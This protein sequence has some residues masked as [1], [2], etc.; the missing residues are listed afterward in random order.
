MKSKI[1]SMIG[2]IAVI[3]PA[4]DAA[5]S[6]H[7][8]NPEQQQARVRQWLA[9]NTIAAGR[10]RG[11]EVV[12]R[13]LLVGINTYEPTAAER[14]RLVASAGKPKA[15]KGRGTFR[16]LDGCVNDVEEMRGLLIARFGFKP[17]NILVLTNQQASRAGILA[18]IE[19][20]LT[21]PSQAGDVAFFFYAGHGSQVVN[22]KSDEEDKLDETIVPAD[23]WSGTPDI[24]DKEL[25]RYF[26]AVLDKQALLTVIFDS[27]HSGSSARG[28]PVARK[29]RHAEPILDDVADGTNYGPSPEERGA[30]VL[31]ASQDDQFAEESSSDVPHGAFTAALLQVLRYT[32]LTRPVTDI[33]LAVHTALQAEGRNQI[34]VLSGVDARR[35][36]GLFGDL[37]GLSG[38]VSAGVLQINAAGEV[39]LAG[40]QAAGLA[41]GCQLRQLVPGAVQ[42]PAI[43]EIFQVD[44]LM[45][46]QAK[47]VSG[48]AATIHGGDVFEVSR[49]VVAPEAML[50]VW[51]QPGDFSADQ[52]TAAFHLAEQLSASTSLEWVVDP[53]L[54]SP[55][56]VLNWTGTQWSLRD[57]SGELARFEAGVDAARVLEITA[58]SGGKPRLF[59]SFPIDRAVRQELKL[60]DGTENSALAL[61]ESPERAHYSLT[62]AY[63][64]GRLRYSWVLPNVAWSSASELP[65]PVRTDWFPTNGQVEVS[66]RYLAQQLMGTALQ[67]GRIRSWLTLAAPDDEGQFPYRLALKNLQTG[68][69]I[70]NGQLQS[71]R[72]AVTELLQLH[73]E[74]VTVTN[75]EKFSLGL[76]AD[77]EAL[78]RSVEQ[79]FVYV[80]TLDSSGGSKLL[81]PRGG[82]GNSQ[83]FPPLKASLNPPDEEIPL[84]VRFTVSEPFG[85]DTYILLTTATA[86]PDATVLEFDPVRKRSAAGERGETNPLQRLLG[87]IGSATRGAHMEVPAN[88]SIE[89]LAVRSVTNTVSAKRL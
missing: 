33:F 55:T 72:S 14:A 9:T 3:L 2:L 34:P 42:A 88:W 75:G 38:R 66:T 84:N 36:L 70:S 89:R 28:T 49:W 25:R 64:H 68:A 62:A 83:R 81:W 41:V 87:S 7:A 45:R 17:E 85:I 40:G 71:D 11:G 63:Q 13:A 39:I 15:K 60:G 61:A 73:P 10:S 4:I 43:L 22:S 23:S 35:R 19:N 86:I 18:S 16:D 59:M 69:Q 50:A 51:L 74:P 82:Q 37:S 47:I 67:L 30:L 53:T 6:S 26:N 76:R 32:P 48:T 65:L 1:L 77:R 20:H 52:A 5:E 78:K 31:S 21:A 56:L 54:V 44:G 29:A 79:R 58:K 12:R 80:F 27:C 57:A 8:V 24:R 46:S